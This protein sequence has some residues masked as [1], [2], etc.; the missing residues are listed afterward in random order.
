M[1][2]SASAAANFDT[3]LGDKGQVQSSK[4]VKDE[5]GNPVLATGAESLQ[6]GVNVGYGSDSDS[7]SSQTKSG[8]NTKNLTVRNEQAQIEKTGKTAEQIKAAVKTDI[9]TETAESR[10]GKLENRFDKDKL[11]KELDYQVKATQEFQTISIATINEK[12]ATHAENKRAEAEQTKAEGNLAKARE[13]ENEAKKWETG[14]AYRQGVDAVTN[15]I[16]LALGGSP[17]AGGITGA[18]SP[19]VN[20]EVKH[21][22]DGNEKANLIDQAIWI[23]HR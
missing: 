11:Q 8:I 20:T 15:A 1:E 10:S 7:Q 12:V 21:A 16:G 4:T 5:S 3:P 23:R 17:T 9:T 13:L 22:T 6:A 18:A 19:Y 2:V 14:G